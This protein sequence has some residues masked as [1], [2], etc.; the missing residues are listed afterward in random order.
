M[1]RFCFVTLL[2]VHVYGNF[3]FCCEVI[4]FY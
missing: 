4:T 3:C 2:D 1:S